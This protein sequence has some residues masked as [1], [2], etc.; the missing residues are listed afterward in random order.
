M[1]RICRRPGSAFP[2]AGEFRRRYEFRHN[3]DAFY[4]GGRHARIRFRGVGVLRLDVDTA[5][6]FACAAKWDR[7]RGRT[8]IEAASAMLRHPVIRRAAA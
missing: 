7:P 8:R 3:S 5:D 2:T 1:R 6:P 4:T